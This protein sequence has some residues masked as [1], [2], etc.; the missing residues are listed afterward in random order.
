MKQSETDP[1]IWTIG[2][3]THG[4]EEFIAMLRSFG[5]ELVVDIRSLPGSRKFPQFDKEKLELSLPA[6]SIRY[7]HLLDLGGRR[8]VKPDSKNTSWHHPAFRGYADFMETETFGKGIEQLETLALEQR[9]TIMCAEAVWWRCHRSMVA[10][11]LKTRGW[12]VN[13]IMGIDKISEH[14][15]TQPARIIDGELT[16]LPATETP[17]T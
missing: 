11:K 5:I 17:S 12:T 1:M 10:D 9:T 8:K 14:P 3:S 15:Y 4:L 16:Y 7:V 13:H 2:H 6:N